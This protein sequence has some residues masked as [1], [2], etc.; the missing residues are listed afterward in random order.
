MPGLQP[1]LS[2]LRD[3][4]PDSPFA[5]LEGD[6]FEGD[7]L[8]ASV[9]VLGLVRL[10]EG[11]LAGTPGALAERLSGAVVLVE[12]LGPPGRDL[13]RWLGEW[14]GAWT[15][16]SGLLQPDEIADF[17]RFVV[18]GTALGEPLPGFARVTVERLS[19]PGRADGAAGLPEPLPFEHLHPDLHDRLAWLAAVASP[20][21]S[22]ELAHLT[23]I[24]APRLE[25]ERVTL[26][27]A[28]WLAA[29]RSDWCLCDHAAVP[30]DA[31]LHRARASRPA[32]AARYAETGSPV[33]AARLLE[34]ALEAG[35]R[36]A[37]DLGLT[38]L[39]GLLAGGHAA[40]AAELAA[41][42]MTA[43]PAEA[44][45]VPLA[46]RALREA[47]RLDAAEAALA[48][49]VPS[50]PLAVERAHLALAR[51]DLP[52][53]LAALEG[54][55]GLPARLLR[56]TTLLEAG[57]GLD[58]QRVLSDAGALPAHTPDALRAEADNLAGKIA[59]HLGDRAAALASFDRLC[60]S[61]LPV[62]RARGFHN[63]ALL[64][65]LDGDQRRAIDL[66]QRAHAIASA[67]GQ[68]YGAALA[69]YNV[70]VA[71]EY[72]GN[73]GVALRFLRDALST[74]RAGGYRSE[75]PM[76]LTAVADVYL[77]LGR[78][79]GARAILRVARSMAVANGQPLQALRVEVREARLDLEVGAVAEA[80]GRLDAA[81][82]ALGEPAPPGDRA[83]ALL[84]RAEARLRLGGGAEL[85]AA[86][87]DALTRDAGALDAELI[88]QLTLVGGVLRRDVGTAECGFAAVERAG[89]PWATFRAAGQVADLMNV[90]GD[91]TRH[92]HWR[93]VAEGWL[94]RFRRRVP[95]DFAAG[96]EQRPDVRRHR[97]LRAGCLLADPRRLEA[98]RG[99]LARASY[100]WLVGTSPAFVDTLARLEEVA[101]LDPAPVLLSGAEGSGRQA[102][103]RALHA[104]SP[105]AHGPF[106]VVGGRAARAAGSIAP[107]LASAEGG[108]LFV[109]EA[110]ALPAATLEA[111]A[112]VVTGRHTEPGAVSHRAPDVRV[113]LA[114]EAAPGA[115]APA[116][117]PALAPAAG[118]LE[119]RVPGLADRRAD[120]PLL[121]AAFVDRLNEAHRA[122]R[123]LA[124]GV[125]ADLA[126]RDWPGQV[127]ALCDEVSR[128]YWIGDAPVAAARTGALDPLPVDLIQMK[129][130]LEVRY[131]R[132][133]L[134]RTDV[135]IAAAARLLG[136]KRPRLSQKIREVG[137]DLDR[138]RRPS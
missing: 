72:L 57:R 38:V 62:M 24:E 45:L 65:L 14:V 79:R 112:H 138:L 90:L 25:R 107:A 123:R 48:E 106:V 136:M 27:R 19:G 117:H 110:A 37:L 10:D 61:T 98:R 5:W 21:S 118:L 96:V 78:L 77:T 36:A 52:A 108:T 71:Y 31:V 120:V 73:Y 35:E 30:D 26:A 119:V 7:A 122:Q 41:R 15:D 20:L 135:N 32:L 58:A 60:T 81:Q 63:K 16:L 76:A 134:V 55:V 44:A 133:A 121:V 59:L 74:F 4:L 129:T 104:V 17:P 114:V 13:A 83:Q 53:A 2:R 97:A 49:A 102:L 28:G 54:A 11:L 84:L 113:V 56:A 115:A 34:L 9:G 8:P 69:L 126:R 18:C 95:A 131:I 111:L 40:R 23:G 46:A 33:L 100:P 99:R 89:N 116:L 87:A 42:L 94:E 137:I 1:S 47:G 39:S 68:W 29:D 3:V 88:G 130:E 80:Q 43:F 125:A 70:G 86:V 124:D 91:A 101:A 12:L 103:A 128:L 66:W 51:G 82:A 93:D 92:A 109:A 64:R 6:A 50:E 75:L 85:K 67:A 132:E 105:R 127:R 22:A